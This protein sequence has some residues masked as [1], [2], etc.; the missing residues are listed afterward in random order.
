VRNGAAVAVVAAVVGLGVVAG[1]SASAGTPAPVGGGSSAAVAAP[2]SAGTPATARDRGASVVATSA[3]RLRGTTSRTGTRTFLGVPFARPP[4]GALRWR[5]PRPVTPWHGV[6]AATSVRSRCVQPPSLDPA[7]IGLVGAEDCLY[8]NVHAPARRPGERLPV[9]VWVHGGSALVGAGSDVDPAR[10]AETG[11]VV[12]VTVNYRLGPFGFLAGPA[13]SAENPRRVSGNYGLL[14][15]LAALRWVQRDVAAFGGDPR[16]VTAFGESAGGVM[17]NQ[18]LTSP[19]ARG[20]LRGAIVQSGPLT[21]RPDGLA[22]AEQSGT[23][24]ATAVGCP[25]TGAAVAACLRAAP[26]ATVLGPWASRSWGSVVDGVVLPEQPLDAMAAGRYLRIPV[27]QGVNHDEATLGI[28]ERFDRRG[29]PLTADIYPFALLYLFGDKAG[30]VLAE[31]PLSGYGSPGE[32]LSAVATDGGFSCSSVR[33]MTNLAQR[34]RV[35]G[36]EFDDP[37]APLR[38]G[39]DDVSFP[40][41]SYHTAE[42]QYVF[43]TAT[44]GTFTP[45][46]RALS[47]RIM[48]YWTSFARYGVPLAAGGPDWRPFDA[49]NAASPG[50]HRLAP[51][52]A[53]ARPPFAADHHCA[54]W[55][56]YAGGQP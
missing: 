3:G 22:A 17:I 23:T 35:Y 49:R 39:D 51:R 19:L 6:R 18:L 8:L 25:G 38:P 30:S 26:A 9:M 46:Q 28:A 45:A 55:A 7:A 31:Y 15:V 42:I 50:I 36:Y 52:G 14:D 27:V 32:A 11:R 12:V 4:V 47:R 53:P 48:G 37:D 44:S 33:D 34:T 2:A 13:L 10:L 56:A 21:I 29:T 20:L 40:L 5:A 43:G 54:F 16:R 41:G 24:Y 1:P